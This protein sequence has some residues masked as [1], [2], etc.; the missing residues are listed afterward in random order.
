MNNFFLA[1]LVALAAIPLIFCAA[2]L[3]GTILYWIWPVTMVDVFHLPMLTWWQAVCLT[4]TAHILVRA[5][6]SNTNK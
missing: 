1:G 2:I 3:S 5:S 6:Q 4:W